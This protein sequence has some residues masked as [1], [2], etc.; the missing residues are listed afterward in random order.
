MPIS[1]VVGK[2]RVL[3]S[4]VSKA[5]ET[6]AA[7]GSARECA[8]AAIK[9]AAGYAEILP[10]VATPPAM[11]NSDT[12]GAMPFE[13]EEQVASPPTARASE[14]PQCHKQ[15]AAAVVELRLFCERQVQAVGSGC[16]HLTEE[17]QLHSSRGC[18]HVDE[19]AHKLVVASLGAARDRLIHCV[20]L[21]SADGIRQAG[22]PAITGS[23]SDH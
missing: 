5:T 11:P 16:P 20:G 12:C 1:Q 7:T 4:A 19:E 8:L 10:S 2:S 21:T 3:L 6:L 9:R 13:K 22:E 18:A 17:A 14:P 23:R 15:L